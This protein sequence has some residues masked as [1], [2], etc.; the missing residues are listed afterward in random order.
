VALVYNYFIYNLSW[1][2]LPQTYRC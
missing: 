1:S 2:R